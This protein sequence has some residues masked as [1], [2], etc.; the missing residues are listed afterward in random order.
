V[1]I[2]TARATSRAELVAHDAE[3]SLARVFREDI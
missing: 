2:G 1:F 3:Q